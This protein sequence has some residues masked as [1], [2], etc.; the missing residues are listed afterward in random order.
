[1]SDLDVQILSVL[2]E[3]RDLL[4]LIA[5][6][7]IAER[8]KKLRDVLRGLVGS[9]KTNKAKAVLLMD[10][11]RTQAKIVE[12]CGI[13]KGQLSGLVKALRE[14]GILRSDAKQPGLALSLPPNFFDTPEV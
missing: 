7:A 13:D 4:R 9:A 12:E 5:E 8:D 1:M 10:G 6:P 2:E 11:T 14:A 3:M